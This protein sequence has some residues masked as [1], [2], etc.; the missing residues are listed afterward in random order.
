VA[1][2][3]GSDGELMEIMRLTRKAKRAIKARKFPAGLSQD[4]R[5]LMA[6][7]SMADDK[8]MYSEN[9]FDLID[10]LLS[11]CGGDAELAIDAV[12]SGRCNLEKTN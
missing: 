1:R 12:L 3:Q 8:G 5:L 11:A 6:V 2:E 9:A 10:E 7:L 4:E